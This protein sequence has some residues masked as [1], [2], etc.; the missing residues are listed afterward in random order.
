MHCMTACAPRPLALPDH[1]EVCI[2]HVDS[3]TISSQLHDAAQG[4]AVP[5]PAVPRLNA[6]HCSLIAHYYGTLNTSLL[7]DCMNVRPEPSRARPSSPHPDSL[8][9]RISYSASSRPGSP[10]PSCNMHS[11]FDAKPRMPSYGSAGTYRTPASS[12]VETC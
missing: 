8:V 7:Y 9:S 6:T 4:Q 10:A 3:S 2:F 11:I 12:A 5:C 1:C